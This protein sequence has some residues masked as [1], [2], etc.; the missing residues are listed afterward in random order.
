MSKNHF[1]L[2]VLT[3]SLLTMMFLGVFWVGGKLVTAQDN[4]TETGEGLVASTSSAP[5]NN[6]A[7]LGISPITTGTTTGE[8]LG[9]KAAPTN[10]NS[11]LAVQAN[12][13]HWF[14]LGSHLLGRGSGM[15]YVYGG[16]GCMYITNSGGIIRM[17]FPV[18]L[19]D[20]AIVKSMDITYYD[21]S[22]SNLTVWL[23]AYDP[24]AT[25]LDITEVSS[26]GTAGLGSVNGAETTHTINNGT[27][28]YSLNYSWGG[29]EDSTLQICGIRINYI[30]PFHA[31]FLPTILKN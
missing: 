2:I 18:S 25:S 5:A 21:T 1:F 6:E 13:S 26:T 8:G 30:D 17:Q 23:T 19:P 4:T 15:Q 29:V 28:A 16:N 14:I 24:G 10:I 9:D 20:G 11:P 22:A 3:S 12:M 27:Q 31:S 7:M